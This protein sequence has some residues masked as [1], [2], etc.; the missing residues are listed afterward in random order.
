MVLLLMTGVLGACDRQS[1]PS[2]QDNAATANISAAVTPDEV[3]SS[4]SGTNDTAFKFTLDRGKAGAAAPKFVFVAPG[5][6]DATLQDFTG[7]P[8]LVNLWA[9]W[10]TPC[11]AEMPTLDAVA[12]QYAPQGLQVLTISQDTQGAAQVDP[13]FARRKFTHLKAWL[14]PENQFGFHYATGLLP[15]SVLYDANGREVAR[16]IGAMDWQ[17]AEA[18]ALLDETVG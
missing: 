16:V 3:P 9:T 5:G 17:G 6:G 14:D 10:C 7:K 12:G 1:P 11:V 15:T 4:G 8:L 2:G 13:F 18:K